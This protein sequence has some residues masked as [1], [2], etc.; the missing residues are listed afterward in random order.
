MSLF[1][2]KYFSIEQ[3]NVAMKVGTDAFV[4]GATVNN[5][6]KV[7]ALDIG[8]GSGVLALMLA[9]QNTSLQVTGIELDKASADVAKRNFENSPWST[10]LKL[11]Q[12]DF[13]EFQTD[14][15]FDLIVSNPPYFE[16]GLLNENQRK[17][18]SRHEQSLPIQSLF[19]KVKELL[20]D[21]GSFWLILP[22]ENVEKWISYSSKIGLYCRFNQLVYGKPN[23]PK[24]AILSFS[25][26]EGDCTQSELIIRTS[27]GS[28]T[29]EYK[30]LT[31]E[32]HGVSLK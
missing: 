21:N 11:I 6:G 30:K 26:V 27:E 12:C 17:S 18:N 1:K 10:N 32:F 5:K 14:T 7:K 9:Q 24:R 4:L 2:F 31:C 8:T 25:K 28:Y 13:L 20:T 22:C 29:E 15:K 16:N 19:D 3:D 23:V